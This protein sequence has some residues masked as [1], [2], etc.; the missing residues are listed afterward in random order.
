MKFNSFYQ[1]L[2]EASEDDAVVNNMVQIEHE[3]NKQIKAPDFRKHYDARIIIDT[4]NNKGW[5]S[6]G[7]NQ[8]EELSSMAKIEIA[9]R[10]LKAK[11][12]FD[13]KI[14]RI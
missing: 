13:L 8:P 9:I 12:I 2:S 6:I 1:S 14:K 4:K 3:D 11:G 5:L 7:G 10:E